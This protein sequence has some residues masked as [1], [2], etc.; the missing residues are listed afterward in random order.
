VVLVRVQDRMLTP[1]ALMSGFGRLL[2]SKVT[3]PRLLNDAMVF[4]V[5]LN[6]PT[7]YDAS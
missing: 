3:G 4:V 6:A 2:P 5:W 1:G 7:V